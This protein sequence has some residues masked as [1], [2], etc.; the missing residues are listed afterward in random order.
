MKWY[1]AVVKPDSNDALGGCRPD[2]VGYQTKGNFYLENPRR[3]RASARFKRFGRR[4]A[5]PAIYTWRF[6]RFIGATCVSCAKRRIKVQP[7]CSFSS[8]YPRYGLFFKFHAYRPTWKLSYPPL[9]SHA[10][11]SSICP[12]VSTRSGS[13]SGWIMR[14]NVLH[15]LF[16]LHLRI[17]K[18]KCLYNG[19]RNGLFYWR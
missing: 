17:I 7:D 1:E 3:R 10:T 19:R 2:L 18:N 16:Y 12:C 8:L 15:L 11:I 4:S 14:S 9:N 13:I 5:R 6:M